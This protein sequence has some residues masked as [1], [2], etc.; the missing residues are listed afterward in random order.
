MS[1]LSIPVIQT[2][3]LVLGAG[4]AGL[5]AALHVAPAEPVLAHV[6]AAFAE[7]FFAAQPDAP[8]ADGARLPEGPAAPSAKKD[9]SHFIHRAS[10]FS[11]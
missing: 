7:V 6:P 1:K 11:S 5:C 8:A 10:A 3:M 2:D 9:C 4:G